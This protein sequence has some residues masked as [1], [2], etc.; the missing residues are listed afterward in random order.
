M[1]FERDGRAEELPRSPWRKVSRGGGG[2]LDGRVVNL[3]RKNAN[4]NSNS[5]HKIR[6][7]TS[8]PGHQSFKFGHTDNRRFPNQHPFSTPSNF[9]TLVRDKS[10]IFNNIQPK[11]SSCPILNNSH[12]AARDTLK[13]CKL[14]ETPVFR[15]FIDELQ[16]SSV[17]VE[18]RQANTTI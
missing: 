9:Y 15:K 5:T 10:A 17:K 16:A 2:G 13:C 7:D 18:L 14:N 8:K 6:S 1:V 3:K 11:I 12:S 4:S